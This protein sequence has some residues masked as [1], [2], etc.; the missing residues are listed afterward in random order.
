[1][2]NHSMNHQVAKDCTYNEI[3]VLHE[4]F[5]ASYKCSVNTGQPNRPGVLVQ[6]L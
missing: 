3:G 4:V 1:M 6:A 2:P 5:T